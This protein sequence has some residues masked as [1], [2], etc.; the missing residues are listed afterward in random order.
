LI[1]PEANWAQLDAED[2]IRLAAAIGIDGFY[3][4]MW[5]CDQS[6]GEER[7]VK[8]DEAKERAE[9]FFSFP[10]LFLLDSL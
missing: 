3:L 10:L 7:S 1:R 5:V 4:N 6:K 2:D 9:A 8:R